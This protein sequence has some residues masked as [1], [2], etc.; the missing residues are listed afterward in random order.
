MYKVQEKYKNIRGKKWE[1]VMNTAKFSV[2]SKWES[3]F[4]IRHYA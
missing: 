4:R 1:H 3:K 2:E